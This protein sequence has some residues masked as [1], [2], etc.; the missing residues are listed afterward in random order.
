V[1][2]A[3]TRIRLCGRFALE[4]DGRDVGAEVP[5]GQAGALL[6]YLLTSSSRSAERDALVDVVWPKD[7]PKD[8]QA[9]L[10]P[11][12]SR[13]RRALA[14]ATL[15]GRERLQLA[16]PEP[17][18]CDAEEAAL[19]VEAARLA[20]QGGDWRA[21][22]ERSRRALELLE[23]GF[24]P[25]HDG[26]WATRR[27]EELRELEAEAL[28]LAARGELQAGGGAAAQ[29]TAR[30]LVARFPFRE[31]G[32]RLLMEA[33]AATGNVAEA[34]RV[35][36]ELRLMLRDELGV[37]P[38]AEVQALHRRLL[39]GEPDPRRRPTAALPAMLSPRERGAFIGRGS[40]LEA[41]RT[42]W[43]A[44]REG[45]RRLVVL[46][47]E[48]GIGKTRLTSELALEAHEQGTVLYAACQED[49]LV[50][51]Q[52]FVEALR[53]YARAGA[54]APPGGPGAAELGRLIPELAPAG[55]QAPSE[56][57]PETRRWLMFDA[58]ATLLAQAPVPVLLVLDDLH[59][60]DRPT[61][62]L[63]RHVVKAPEQAPLLIVGTYRASEVGPQLSEL[64]ADLR[65]DRLFERISLA[66]LDAG[67]VGALI[68]THAGH[69]APAALVHAVHEATEGNPFFVEEVMRHLIETGAV[70]ERD[71]RWT[72]ALAVEDMGVPEGVKEVLE[73][74]LSHLS[75]GCRSILSQAAVLGREFPFEVLRAMAGADDEQAIAAVEEALRAQLV[76]ES[77]QLYAFTHALVRETLYGGISAPRRQRLHARAAEAIERAEGERRVA[78]LAVHHRLAGPAG[79]RE[80]AVE[81]SLRAG[82]Q[83]R[84]VFAWEEASAH[85]EG[86]LEAMDRLGRDPAER[87]RL[88]VALSELMAVVGDLGRQIEHLERALALYEELGDEE[89][90]AHVH[91]RLGMAHSLIDSIWAEHMDIRRAFHHFDAARR[92]LDR[93]PVRKAR[94]H[95]DTG[96]ATA[97]TYGLDV[98][99]GSEAAARAMEIGE[100]LGDEALWSGAAQAY[101]WHRLM[102][103]ALE[104][105][106]RFME[107]GF[108]AADRGRKPLL[109]WM[110]STMRG[111]MTWGLGD[112]DGAQPFFERAVTLSYAGKTAYRQQEAD[113][114]GRCHASRGEMDQAR[115]LLTDAV[116]SWVTHS[117]KPLVD[118]WDGRW[119]E[120]EALAGNVLETS[121]RNGNRWDE[122]ASHHL[123]AR[124]Q[125]LRGRPAEAAESLEHALAIV[126]DGNARYFETWVRPDL[127]RALAETGRVEEAREHV[128]RCAEIMAGGEDWRGRA[129]HVAVA[130]AVV[131]R[132]EGSSPDAAFERAVEAF[133]RHRLPGDEADALREWGKLDA[134][135][136]IY[137]RHGAGAVWLTR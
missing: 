30:E 95:L 85:W 81:F 122:W 4:I 3:A 68:A 112:P 135:R 26:E 59:W 61:L 21:A 119:D 73:R 37:A 98:E 34:L 70:F 22:S 107:R 86:A 40:E 113:G 56:D 55:S 41:L 62:Q 128:E 39:D 84:G 60:A 69:E 50:S 24:L 125:S 130:E 48:P 88:L 16:L 47:G 104:E 127:A 5:S 14:P 64:L 38:A 87:A 117:L 129:G 51:Y 102:G 32:H 12:L 65:R 42:A 118:L 46:T 9:Q 109:A 15:E 1:D 99:R 6:R 106:F 71:G 133:R 121:R 54:H 27:R 31:S 123:A 11:I 76:V 63:L 36:D 103:G 111:H 78:A 20:A 80:R 132:Q 13:L 93:G 100:Q 79:D 90:A 19:A 58:V 101:G 110:A 53:H 82:E 120:V 7:P 77:G 134:A 49:A 94:G 72:S 17:V 97:L 33:L 45:R 43:G 29:A 2:E 23:P 67:D 91:S 105:G 52:P 92:V 137:R 83:A 131:L 18:W 28:E 66:G 124:V 25:G 89:R 115:L 74:R 75:D 57:D 136:E 35:Y 44:A 116:P 108:E 8:P 10:R 126:V 96:V 114:L